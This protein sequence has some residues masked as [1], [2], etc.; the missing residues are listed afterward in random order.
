MKIRQINM[1]VVIIPS[2]DIFLLITLFFLISGNLLY[3]SAVNVELPPAVSQ[4]I[5]TSDNPVV[6]LTPGGGIFL[7]GRKIS[8]DGLSMLLQFTA[9][10]SEKKKEEALLIIRADQRVSHQHLVEIIATAKDSGIKRIAIATEPLKIE[11]Q[12]LA[13]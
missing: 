8:R 1:S 10:L 9:R 7:N 12:E 6:T 4:H 2:M 13:R 3:Q 11:D 5:V